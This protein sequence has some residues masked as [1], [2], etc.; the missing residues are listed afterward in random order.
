M[1]TR[2]TINLTGDRQL[3]F[4]FNEFDDNQIFDK[5]YLL[6]ELKEEKIIV[7]KNFMFER[8][9]IINFE[10]RENLSTTPTLKGSGLKKSSWLD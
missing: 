2:I 5:L 6:R 8:S 10:V 9:E 3:N 7:Y 4:N 1:I